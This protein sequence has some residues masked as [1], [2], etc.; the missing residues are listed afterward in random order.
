[1]NVKLIIHQGHTMKSK[2]DWK[3]SK[4]MPESQIMAAAKLD[5]D[6]QP[7]R[8]AQ[9]KKFKRVFSLAETNIN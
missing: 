1:M 7:L 5:V 2:T 4:S 8:K 3:K 6:M 9:L